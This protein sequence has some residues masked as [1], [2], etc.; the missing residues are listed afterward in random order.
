MANV[1]TLDGGATATELRRAARFLRSIP[2]LRIELGTELTQLEQQAAAAAPAGANPNPELSIQLAIRIQRLRDDL[3]YLN[4]NRLTRFLI[5]LLAENGKVT[6]HRLQIIA[7]TTVLGIVFVSKVK[8]ELAMPVFS[9]T[10]LGLMGLSS[11]T[12]VALKVP[13]LKKT[14]ADVAA[15]ADAPLPVA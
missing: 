5:D 1:L 6:L 3:E 15:A 4:H 8:R 10:L 2:Q 13:E 7:W 9:D 12:Y 14:Q 11:L